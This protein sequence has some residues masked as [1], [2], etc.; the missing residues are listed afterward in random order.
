MNVIFI[1]NMISFKYGIYMLYF[2]VTNLY[3]NLL[4]TR[5]NKNEK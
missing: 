1:K 3:W 2:I 5:R 4:G